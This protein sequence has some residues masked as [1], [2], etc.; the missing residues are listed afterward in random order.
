[1]AEEL[2]YMAAR[3]TDPGLAGLAGTLGNLAH[4]ASLGERNLP[5]TPPPPPGA[6]S[7]RGPA[8]AAPV[9][10][11]SV[12]F[13][14]TIIAGNA[15]RLAGWLQGR[16]ATA[17]IADYAP[18]YLGYKADY[19]CES[20]DRANIQQFADSMLTLARQFDIISLEFAS[21]F[22]FLPWVSSSFN[23]NVPFDPKEPY[24]DL[25]PL[26][27]AGKKIF[28]TFWG[29]DCFSQSYIHYYYLKYLGL[30][31]LPAP[32]WQ[33]RNQY[34]NIV[35]INQL[36]DAI[37]APSYFDAVLPRI[38]PFWDVSI[39]LS[40][41]PLKSAYRPEVKK[42]LTAPTSGRKKN[43]DLI[44]SCLSDLNVRYP[45]IETLHVR[46]TPA[47]LVPD[48]YAQ[49]DLG[50]EQGTNGF[51]L[52]AVEM[53][54]LGLPVVGNYS[55]PPDSGHHREEA[56]LL[57]FGN[58]RELYARIEQCVQNPAALPA[59][60]RQGRQ[61]VEE[62]HDIEVMGRAF[63]HYV[64][65]ALH[66]EVRHIESQKYIQNSA[67]WSQNPETVY[68]FRYYDISV[69]LFCLLGCHDQALYDS[70]E[71]INNGY[72]VKKFLAW[73]HSIQQKRGLAGADEVKK[74][75][76]AQGERDVVAMWGHYF[77]LL[78]DARALLKE[79]SLMLKQAKSMA[80]GQG[81]SS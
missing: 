12:L 27:K 10:D 45:D 1:M 80:L 64:N 44:H 14:P 31:D 7:G 28:F 68:A 81:R 72:R 76:L 48:I 74:D 66:G 56:P 25:L 62:Y 65:Q 35:A 77:N 33:D 8:Q 36:A 19:R 37:L 79:A 47:H 57:K 67:I 23:L 40:M 11:I 54:A 22:K 3:E 51:G 20:H 55:F 4:P 58:I 13:A 24:R 41:W 29:S 69:P 42:I 32:P 73:N 63:S 39:D 30:G 59:L 26:K 34:E 43:Y 17:K 6:A 75:L 71:A 53:M 2:Q 18:N 9:K 70:H 78:G 46:N 49:A 60:G 5:L 61:Y 50:I 52:L 38:V 21:S 16:Q 15:P